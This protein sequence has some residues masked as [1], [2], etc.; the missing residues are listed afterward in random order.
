M[1]WTAPPFPTPRYRE[2]PLDTAQ[3]L[4]VLS[5]CRAWYRLAIP[6][7]YEAV[8]FRR[9]EQAYLLVRTLRGKEGEG[10]RGLVRSLAFC[11][12][13]PD[14]GNALHRRQAAKLLELC[15]NLVRLAIGDD[16]LV[17]G[18]GLGGNVD[19][20]RFEHWP[21][22]AGG[23]GGIGSL[24]FCTTPMFYADIHPI[25]GILAGTLRT[26]ALPEIIGLGMYDAPV[27]T[28]PRLTHLRVVLSSQN[29]MEL[30][31]FPALRHLTIERP[32]GWEHQSCTNI[33]LAL[34]DSLSPQSTLQSLTHLALP[35]L[36][37]WHG[38]FSPTIFRD[39]QAT[40]RILSLC[41]ALVVLR[42]SIIQLLEFPARNV[43]FP[44]L[45][46]A[47]VEVLDVLGRERWVGDLQEGGNVDVGF[48]RGGMPRLREVRGVEAGVGFFSG[49]EVES[50]SAGDG[51]TSPQADEATAAVPK[52]GLK[53]LIPPAGTWLDFF[54][55]D[56]DIWEDSDA[57]SD[58]SF[59]PESGS[60]DSD[61]SGLEED[62]ESDMSDS[63]EGSSFRTGDSLAADE[64]DDHQ[65]G[66]D[67]ESDGSDDDQDGD[68]FL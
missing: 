3:T 49:A 56:L 48:L 26:L 5:V 55:S 27:L 16:G 6:L 7:L 31:R 43:D 62:S 33:T 32:P 41:P 52:L 1:H 8:V 24:E 58:D 46:H 50:G 14:S 44:A 57:E 4:V 18:V 65:G 64:E 13:V 11:Y 20:S 19:V 38:G 59:E 40:Q 42:L 23:T 37:R 54:L 47:R 67:S 10:I 21:A 2:S 22:L 53:K 15:P 45:Q 9:L 51:E 35:R 28:L 36:D 29:R 66:S 25:L 63:E 17:P 61:N 68:E 34:I 12:V 60:Q 39:F 30:F